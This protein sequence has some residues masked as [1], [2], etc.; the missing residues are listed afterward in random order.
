MR[1]NEKDLCLM[2]LL[3]PSSALRVWIS[4]SRAEGRIGPSRPELIAAIGG[5]GT[6]VYFTIIGNEHS[7]YFRHDDLAAVVCVYIYIY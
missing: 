1:V 7:T 5:G 2:G 6:L 3:A 4:T